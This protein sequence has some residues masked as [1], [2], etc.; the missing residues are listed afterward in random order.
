VLGVVLILVSAVL[1][2]GAQA[3]VSRRSARH[4]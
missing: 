3:I 1:L 2:L 4:S